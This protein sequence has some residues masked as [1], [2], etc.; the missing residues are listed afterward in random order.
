MPPLKK[1]AINLAVAAASLSLFFAFS[2]TAL[3]LAGVQPLSLTEDPFVGFTS[4]QPLFI[5]KKSADGKVMMV[6]NPAKYSHFNRQ[7]FPQVKPPGTYRI[8]CLGGSAT[9]GRPWTDTYAFSGWL[10]RMLPDVDS[11]HPW[12]VINAGGI[13]YASYRAAK[14]M[15]ELIHDQ[16]DLFIVYSGHNE[17]LEERTYRKARQLP[18]FVRTA[19]DLL[20][21]TRTYTAMRLLVRKFASP[22]KIDAAK[23]PAGK[24]EMAGEVDDVLAKTIGPTSYTRDDALQREVLAHYRNSLDRMAR[25][26]QAAG[27][28]ILFLSTPVNEKDC[29]PFKSEHTPGLSAQ[30]TVR[31]DAW[32]QR[33]DAWMQVQRPDSAWP[34]YDSAA[35]LDPRDADALYRAGQAAFALKRYPEAKRLFQAA[36]DQDI[37]PLRALTPMR[38]I[39]REVAAANHA[40]FVDFT[41][42]LERKTQATYG[43]DILGE[44]DFVDHVH[45][46]ISGYALL[47]QAILDKLIA[48]GVVHPRPGWKDSDLAPLQQKVLASVDRKMEALGLDNIAKVLNWAGKHDDAA[49]IAERALKIDTTSLETIWSSLFVG[50]AREREGKESEAIPYYLRAVRMDPNNALSRHYLAGAWM[51]LGRLAEAAAQYDTCLQLDS[52]DTSAQANL[53][54]LYLRLGRP[55]QALP[56]LQRAEAGNPHQTELST[57]LGIAQYQSGL[58]DEAEVSFR[59]A[60]ELN[61]REAWA[62]VGLGYVSDARNQRSAAIQYFT[63][64]LAINPDLTEARVALSRD[65]SQM[66]DARH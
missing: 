16:P 32:M 39:V 18:A 34:V 27:A 19:S 47:A 46:S 58:A 5:E 9:Y 2:E 31:V 1:L 37:C 56:Y 59:H 52:T 54:G 49:R 6:T 57:M 3:R 41:G 25:L 51:R 28:Q 23:N 35:R 17:F 43:Y 4:V 44:P 40:P 45:L 24:F 33:G 38:G 63:Q 62:Y 50:A 29:S 15:N 42:I 64:A 8:F 20:D 65:L 13:S 12:E 21:R 7:S 14:L 22:V 26:A 48:I 36:S 11:S 66:P 55:R 53:G 60:L 10:R 61:P 30:D